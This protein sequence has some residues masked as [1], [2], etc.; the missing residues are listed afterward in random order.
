M[1]IIKK[2]LLIVG[3]TFLTLGVAVGSYIASMTCFRNYEQKDESLKTWMKNINDETRLNEIIMPGSH[4]AGTYGMSWLGATQHLT[5]EEQLNLGVR[6]FD[7]RV[8]K[9]GE[10]YV[11]FH[12]VLNGTKFDPILDSI[13]KFINENP[14]ETLLLDFQH[15]KNGSEE[16]V[17]NEVTKKLGDKLVTHN[18][19]NELHFIDNLSLKE[20]RGKC[21]VFFG[22]D[23]HFTKEKNVFSRNDD[24]CTK[25]GQALDSCYISE[26]HANDS[27]TF[28]DSS[29]DVY[30][31][32]IK[33][34]MKSEGHKG[35]FVLQC[36]LTDK[37]LVFGPFHK[38]RGHEENMSAHIENLAKT[39]YFDVVNVIMR[40]FIDENKTT[41]I[42]NLNKSKGLF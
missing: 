3:V 36:Q 20:T 18:D 5:I 10:E 4:D 24:E 28:I 42:I 13:V 16:Y 17:Y 39:H 30:G 35:I 19:D 9:K 29:L 31:T 1:K 32:K 6:Y 21:I 33:D 7:L 11:M 15:F 8:N 14:S 23:S 22:D 40:D 41:S 27:R 37:S 38:E 25:K 26:Y 34:K 12:S 2:T